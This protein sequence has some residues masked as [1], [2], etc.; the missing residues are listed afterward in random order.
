MR[1]SLDITI[2]KLIVA[3]GSGYL[4]T[5]LLVGLAFLLF[6]LERQDPAAR[7]AYAFRPLLLPGLALLWPLVLLRWS[8]PRPAQAAVTVARHKRAHRMIWAALLLIII[9]TI[10][11]AVSIRPAKLPEQPSLRLSLGSGS[12]A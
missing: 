5:G 7:G 9:V 4:I 6:R 12:V 1:D 3:V 10:G 8:F 2:A 11:L